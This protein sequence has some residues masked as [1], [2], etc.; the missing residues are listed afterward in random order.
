MVLKNLKIEVTMQ[1]IY[2]NLVITIKQCLQ[3][4]KY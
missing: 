1:V 2:F 4:I 3:S